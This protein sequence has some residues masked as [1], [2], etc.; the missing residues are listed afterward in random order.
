MGIFAKFLKEN[1]EL[2][3]NSL[4]LT[5]MSNLGLKLFL[6]SEGINFF[7]TKVGDRY[8]YESLFQNDLIIGGEQSGHII[9]L[10]YN[11][12]GD[13]VLTALELIAAVKQSGKKLSQLG[14]LMIRYPQLLV[15]VRLKSKEGW[16]SNPV[17]SAAIAAGEERLGDNGRILVRPSGTEPLIRVMA[18][19]PCQEELEQIVSQIADVIKGE[20]D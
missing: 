5:V 11:T 17:I 8:I 12:T 1:G 19:G 2:K 14:A 18:E 9:Y 6:Q 7:E 20:L 16:D 15:N 3:N 10:D 13:G 4:A